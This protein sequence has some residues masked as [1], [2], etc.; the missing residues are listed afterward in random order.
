MAVT[1]GRATDSVFC[2]RLA[3][4][5]VAGMSHAAYPTLAGKVAVRRLAAG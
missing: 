1:L 3:P 5:L 2:F 4:G